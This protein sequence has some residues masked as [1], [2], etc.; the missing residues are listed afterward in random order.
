MCYDVILAVCSLTCGAV[1]KMKMLQDLQ[2][3]IRA[4]KKQS[5]KQHKLAS[6][7]FK[8]GKLSKAVLEHLLSNWCSL[9][10]LLQAEW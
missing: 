1:Q 5:M 10:S 7:V 6:F 8:V 3:E 9:T 2:C 4:K